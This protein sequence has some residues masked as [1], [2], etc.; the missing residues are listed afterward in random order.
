MG[1]AGGTQGTTP[2][3]VGD[4]GAADMGRAAFAE[5]GATGHGLGQV[6]PGLHRVEGSFPETRVSEQV[7]TPAFGDS[8]VQG[9][10]GGAASQP[11]MSIAHG[12]SCRIA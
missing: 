8:W 3:D 4:A 9:V 7:N 2:G 10:R 5:G 6:D 1:H 11:H 12:V